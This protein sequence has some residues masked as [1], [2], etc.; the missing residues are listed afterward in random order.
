M[1]VALCFLIL[2][3]WD[4]LS[5]LSQIGTERKEDLLTNACTSSAPTEG[6]VGDESN[7]SGGSL[8]NQARD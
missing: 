4:R 5:F 3:T 2:G 1:R 8:W 6:R 7:G